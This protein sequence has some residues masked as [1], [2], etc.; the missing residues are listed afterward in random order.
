VNV[1][2]IPTLTD[3]VDKLDLTA[4]EAAAG[5]L[6]D[7]DVT[8][9]GDESFEGG[10]VVISGLLDGD[11]VELRTGDGSPISLTP[12]PNLPG[13]AISSSEVGTSVPS[14]M[15]HRVGHRSS[16]MR[17][18]TAA[19]IEAILEN[20]VFRTTGTG[21]TRD[22]TIQINDANSDFDTQVI[23][24]NIL[25]PGAKEMSYQIL[26]VVNGNLE[27]IEA[28]F[29][30]TGDLNPSDL[31]G[32]QTPPDTF[33]VEYSG[34]L[35][36]GQPGPGE[37]SVFAFRDVAP[38]TVLI[39]DGASYT[40]E[41]PEGRLAL[42]LGPGLHKITLQVPYESTPPMVS[43]PPILTFGTTRTPEDSGDPWPNY[44]E[45]PLFDNV[46]TVPD[47]LHRVEVTSTIT[48]P[49]NGA[50][51]ELTHVFYVT[52]LDDIPAQL[53]ALRIQINPPQFLTFSQTY[54]TT[55]EMLGTTGADT[56]AGTDGTDLQNGGAGD[57]TLL[58][59]LGADT[60]DGGTG[61]NTVSYEASDARV[62]VDLSKGVG[63][64]G[65]AEG[66]VLRNIQ[67]VLGSAFG[68][69]LVGSAGND[70]LS[71]LEGRDSVVGG[72]GND[73][74]LGGLGN[75]TLEGGEGDD[76]LGGGAGADRLM[77]GDGNDT[78]RGGA[79][80]DR[81]DGGAGTNRVSYIDSDAAVTV[82]LEGGQNLGGHAAGDRLFNIQQV[83]GSAFDDVLI[84]RNAGAD[85]LFGGAGDDSL[86]GNAG[87]DR[88]F[89]DAGDDTLVGDGGADR[90][91][92]GAGNDSLSGGDGNDWLEGGA[93]ADTLDGGLGRHCE[94]CRC[95][96]GRDRQ[97]G[98][99]RGL[100]G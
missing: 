44:T 19:D 51:I 88:L 47:T 84:G 7:A 11:V 66:D 75:D 27:P 2:Y 94:L 10:G 100:A 81:I 53:A 82:D 83:V 71:G 22:I 38:G 13:T 3:M 1:G 14:M 60:L 86:D 45:T 20:L 95:F 49:A 48:N 72:A 28:L 43:T 30:T 54:T 99:R 85:T 24:V 89:G 35:N 6:L 39:V 64:G 41:G 98:R 16:P 63:Q 62:T 15:I 5:Q 80:A 74:L 68:D 97:S 36:V 12:N 31:F 90:L 33:V 57:D 65:H 59:S 40:L 70:T 96:N 69:H 8:F 21:A 78:L 50:E 23:T 18:A 77:G 87:A 9:K 58:G 34:L 32:T 67:A 61:V 76:L 92:G 55:T 25:P 56:L 37:Q 26:R 4:A 46:Q 91:F 73:L 93:G 29:G 42:D 52:S 79:G 17:D